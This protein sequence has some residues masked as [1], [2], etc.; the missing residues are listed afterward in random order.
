MIELSETLKTKG[1]NKG[2]NFRLTVFLSLLAFFCAAFI[3]LSPQAFI[4]QL[5][6]LLLPQAFIAQL[7]FIHLFNYICDVDYFVTCKQVE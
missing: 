6:S 4:A 5:L 2:N 3:I 1:S 7:L